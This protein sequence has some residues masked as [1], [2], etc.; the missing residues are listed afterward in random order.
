MAKTYEISPAQLDWLRHEVADWERGGLVDDAGAAAILERYVASRRTTVVRL[1]SVLGAA[2]VGVGLISLVASNVDELSPGLR[3][4]GIVVVWLSAVVV[5]E[6]LRRRLPDHDA[7]GDGADRSIAVGSARLIAV[8]AYGAT[9]FQ[10]AQSLQVPAYSSGLLGCWAA[11]AL[12][13]AYAVRGLGPLLVGIA[14]MVG[15]FAWALGER[16]GDGTAFIAGLLIASVLATAV[17]VVHEQ[18]VSGALERFAAPWSVVGALLALVAL[19]GAALPDLGREGLQLPA[20]GIVGLVVALALSAAAAGRAEPQARRELAAVVAMLAAGL[21]LAAWAPADAVGTLSGVE[22]SHALV[23]TVVYLAASVWFAVVGAARD[24][25][26][27]VN[28]AT[29]GLVLFVTVQSFG[30]FAPLLSGAAL[31]LILGVI[32]IGVGAVAERG[33]RRL[34][35]EVTE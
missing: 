3:F 11:G 24:R 21:G 6:A 33:R 25:P 20:L 12:A 35:E 31:F 28:L 30:V 27:L 18:L 32:L 15:W 34:L 10:A 2:F 1:L 9:I 23:G 19:F 29:A 13:Y 8:A 4:L 16:A 14:T 17:A 7:L 5:A 26:Q 22:L